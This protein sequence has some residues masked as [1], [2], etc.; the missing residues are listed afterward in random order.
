M[1]VRRDGDGQIYVVYANQQD[2]LAE[3]LPPDNAELVAWLI[4]NDQRG[5]AAWPES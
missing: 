1:Y 5:G 2:P 3:Y 4:E